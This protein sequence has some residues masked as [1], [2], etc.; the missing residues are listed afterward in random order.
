M[1]SNIGLSSQYCNIIWGRAEGKQNIELVFTRELTCT[2]NESCK[3][4][5]S[6]FIEAGE[7]EVNYV[8]QDSDLRAYLD[9]FREIK[10]KMHVHSFEA[11]SER[12]YGD[13]D[14][15]RKIENSLLSLMK[16]AKAAGK[17]VARFAVAVPAPQ[18]LVQGEEMLGLEKRVGSDLRM[19]VL[20]WDVL[21]K[22][23]LSLTSI[24]EYQKLTL[25][26][27]HF[28]FI[29]SPIPG[30]PPSPVEL[31]WANATV[32]K[33]ISNGNPMGIDVIKVTPSPDDPQKLMIFEYRSR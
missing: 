17:K 33:S 6:N 18:V 2:A 21:V 16:T 19:S 5:W 32:K 31:E 11:E 29:A 20:D 4:D 14:S 1:F 15:N 12:M 9:I 3:V 26:N 28:L 24:E 7:L 27:N 8:I 13:F 25:L 23:A 30:E 22:T 10:Y